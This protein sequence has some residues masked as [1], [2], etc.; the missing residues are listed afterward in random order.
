MHTH[1]KKERIPDEIE[2]AFQAWD[3]R[4]TGQISTRDLKHI[5]CDWGE[6]L[7]P[8]VVENLLREMNAAF[9]STVNYNDL[10]EVISAPV[11]DYWGN[12][13]YQARKQ[14]SKQVTPVRLID[15]SGT[16]AYPTFT[17]NH[18]NEAFTQSAL[19]SPLLEDILHEHDDAVA[20]PVTCLQNLNKHS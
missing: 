18:H 10:L 7:E 6:K 13:S 9:K 14:A 19:L 16:F 2:E 5:L 4:R 12:T 1:S 3:A 15:S 20:L 11:P 8:K 17:G